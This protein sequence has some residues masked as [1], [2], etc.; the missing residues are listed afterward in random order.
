MKSSSK[1]NSKSRALQVGLVGCGNIS[2]AY[3]KGLKPFGEWLDI[4]ACA[5]LDPARARAK[6]DEHGV[7][8]ACTMDELLASS[9]D[10]VLNLTTPQAHAAVNLA[11]LRAGKHVYCEKPF[12]LNVKEGAK[13]LAE[14]AK[15]KLRVGCAPDTVLGAGVQTARKLIDD[16]VIGRPVSF[17]ANM[18]GPGHESWHPSPEFYY[19]KGGGPLFDMG[20]YYLSSLITCFGPVKSVTAMAAT[21]F[22]TRVITSQPKRGQ[23]IKVETPTHLTGAVEFVS[24]AIGAVTMS[25]DVQGHHLPNLEIFGT[26]SSLACPDPN[27]FSGD[28]RLWKAETKEWLSMPLSHNPDAGRGYGLADMAHAILHRRPHRANGEIGLHVVEVIEAF[29]LS[30]ARGRQIMLKTSC[31]QPAPLAPGLALGQLEK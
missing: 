23:K 16:G 10:I 31:R 12:S 3:F 8:T 14:A 9:V 2:N 22:K 11:A 25:F 24:G 18:L 26:K 30:A 1:K 29:H 15:R 28:V 19:Q 13:V 17:A 21:T 7:P 6:A 4:V 5:D 20:P 27:H